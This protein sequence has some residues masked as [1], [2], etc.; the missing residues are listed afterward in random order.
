METVRKRGEGSETVH[1]VGGRL[2]TPAVAYDRSAPP[3]RAV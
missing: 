1:R 2:A 3:S